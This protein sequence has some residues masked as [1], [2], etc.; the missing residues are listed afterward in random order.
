MWG[1]ESMDKD[2]GRGKRMMRSR[3]EN[4]KDTDVGSEQDRSKYRTGQW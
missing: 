1:F 4:T 2:I 3:K